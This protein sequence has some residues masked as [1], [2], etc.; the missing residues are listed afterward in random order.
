LDSHADA[1]AFAASKDSDNMH[2]HQM[3]KEP[4]KDKFIAIMVEE[5]EAQPK[6]EEF[7]SHPEVQGSK[8]SIPALHAAY[9]H[10]PNQ[11]P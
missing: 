6:W 5:M 11:P 9:L 4:N 2:L 7:L 10:G 3:M 1:A 8:K